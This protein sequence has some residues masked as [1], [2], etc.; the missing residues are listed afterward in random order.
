MP[1]ATDT[2]T[3]T[4]PIDPPTSARARVLSGL[5]G[6]PTRPAAS[7]AARSAN[8]AATSPHTQVP[9]AKPDALPR[10]AKG[11]VIGGVLLAVAMPASV[12]LSR[13]MLVQA[14]LAEQG[15]SK[16]AMICTA[17]EGRAVDGSSLMGWLFG[18]SYFHCGG[19]ETREARQQRDRDR[20][21]ASFLARERARQQNY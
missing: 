9:T 3:A 4:Q 18:G 5:D 19:W 8:A 10:W 7:T 21:Q 14:A 12:L 17:G 2:F 15:K 16:A 6:A 20:D 13:S 11:V 1:T